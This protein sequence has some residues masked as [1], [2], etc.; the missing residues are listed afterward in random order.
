[1]KFWEA[2]YRRAWHNLIVAS[3]DA[4]ARKVAYWQGRVN[5]YYKLICAAG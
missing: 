1:M 5:H 2:Q 3:N 4:D